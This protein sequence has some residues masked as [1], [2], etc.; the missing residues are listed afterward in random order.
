M[1]LENPPRMALDLQAHHADG[2]AAPLASPPETIHIPDPYMGAAA[3]ALPIHD[4]CFRMA[5]FLCE[6][7]GKKVGG[8]PISWMCK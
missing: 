3:A 6:L 2:E 4:T 8:R 5:V 7:P 1:A